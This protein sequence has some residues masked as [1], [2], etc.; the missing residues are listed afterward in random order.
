M[1]S[2]RIG[3]YRILGDLGSGGMGRVVLV[4]LVDS[5]LGL[6]AGARVALKIIHPHLVESPGFLRRFQREARIGK[7]IRHENV[8]RVL[9]LSSGDLDGQ[10]VHFLVMDY[11]E[12]RT[13]RELLVELNRFPEA[14]LR[15]VAR[16]V[17]AGLAAIHAAGVVH[18]DV[19][20]D[21]VL[22]TD[23]QRV[24]IMDLGV[25]RAQTPTSAITEAGQFAGSLLYAAPEQFQ[26]EPLQ[27]S[28][29]LYA[30][31]VMLYEL[32]TGENPFRRD[33]A[34]SV[35]QAHMN[36]VPPVASER[37][38]DLSAFFCDV[39]AMLLAKEP[40]A[41]FPSAA[42]LCDVL[43]RGERSTWWTEREARVLRTR[44]SIPRIAVSRDTALH[45][46]ESEL[47]ALR[48]AWQQARVGKG[49]TVL[50]E[51]EAGIGKTRLVDAFVT[52]PGGE[53]ARVLYGAYSPSGG[54]GGLSEAILEHL[55]GR[56]LETAL[57][58]YL[59]T[60]PALIPGF[61]AVVRHEAPP[62]GTEPLRAEALH[63]VM[64]NLMRG[65]AARMPL[66][67]VVD[68]LQFAE[69]DSRRVVLSLARAVKR[70]AV[71]LVVCMR[72]GL[73]DDEIAQFTSLETT[74]RLP[75]GR[76]SPRQVIELLRESFHSETLADKLGGKIAYKSDGVPFFVF[77]M[78]RGLREGRFIEAG[79]DGAFIETRVVEDIEVPSA[80]RD[81]LLGRL[82]DLHEG[83]RDL[84]DAAAVQGLDFDGDLLARV[85]DRKRIEVLQRLAAV[86][87]RT[88]LVRAAGAGWR[89]DHHQ[90]QEV[91]YA[92]LPASLRGEYHALLASA[93]AAREGVEP[94]DGKELPG[95]V[96]WFLATHGVRGS[97]PARWASHVVPALRHLFASY[98]NEA[99]VDCGRMALGVEGLLGG[100]TRIA[101]HLRVLESLT[102]LGW[103]E[104]EREH[105]EE[106]ESLAVHSPDLGLRARV[107]RA[108]GAHL[109]SVSRF[110]EAEAAYRVAR[111]LA[112]RADDVEVEAHVTGGL[113]NVATSLGRYEEAAERYAAS[114]A[115][116]RRIGNRRVQAACAGNLGNV[117]WYLGRLEEA[118]RQYE[119]QLEISREDDEPHGQALALGNLAIVLAQTGRFE[120]AR[121][122]YE[123]ALALH[124]RSG[125]RRGETWAR[126]S[127]SG[128]LGDLGRFKEAL[129]QAER[130]LE[131]ARELEDR[132]GQAQAAG[133]VGTHLLQLGRF[134]AARP[135]LE[136]TLELSRETADPRGE[137]AA[138]QN[139]AELS[140]RQGDLDA[141]LRGAEEAVRRQRDLENRHGLVT[142]LLLLADVE[143]RLGREPSARARL[144]ELLGIAKADEERDEVVL[145][146]A[147]RAVLDPRR[148]AEALATLREHE[149]YLKHVTRL[150]VHYMLWRASGAR[151]LL[152]AAHRYLESTCANAPEEDW[153]SMLE[154]V[155]LY[156]DIVRAWNDARVEEDPS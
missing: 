147:H 137:A 94:G 69:P 63:A 36:L 37:N 15:E 90:L 153:V 95:E 125:D 155:P 151:D 152:Q 40:G 73:P 119:R 64:V 120:E 2:D 134:E 131:L 85:V 9:D 133:S 14:L 100:D 108:R 129:V 83:E 72:P 107:A 127:L 84:L 122:L 79:R 18:R 112:R 111:D 33:F 89:F 28:A 124:R 117:W 144:E 58:P 11:V 105:L 93:F 44:R 92:G 101:V 104:A 61:A 66:I 148:A 60:T 56:D 54:M 80:V 57:Q 21:N 30:L 106:A 48:E 102:V 17:A 19:K 146:Q 81:L 82:G 97:E 50:V 35:I 132:R 74:Q 20:P 41:R 139:L 7:E 75:V 47:A 43:Q 45:G 87:R 70:H 88:Q 67:W 52:D 6:P 4:E 91:V 126:R 1:A 123:Q 77:E 115:L 53:G 27:A 141:A 65:L 116:A 31:G 5:R 34:A 103:R 25:A 13:L 26:N 29:D 149:P 62:A 156:R 143:T 23:D 32:A 99:A 118:R 42:A 59:E 130:A 145:A 78:I 49:R 51:G 135:M 154:N 68:D 86:E 71:L 110:D 138:I 46:R 24:Q 76:L 142:A 113:G 16:Q 55:G 38:P 136:R 12:G 128:S 98:R 109:F 150:S 8:V 22:I 140:V 39:L 114:D 96:H 121:E 3:P 10:P